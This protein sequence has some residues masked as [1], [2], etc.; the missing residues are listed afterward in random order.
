MAGT[1][2]RFASWAFSIVFLLSALALF[3]KNVVTALWLL[4]AGVVLLPPTANQ[5]AKLT[6]WT[7]PR[8]ARITAGIIGCVAL[9][10]LP[11]QYAP[12][13]TSNESIVA[14][15]FK[16]ES[17]NALGDG[18]M[19]Y[20]YISRDGKYG[21]KFFAPAI[22]PDFDA[23]YVLENTDET[24]DSTSVTYAF[25]EKTT[26]GDAVTTEAYEALQF[27]F[28]REGKLYA[29]FVRRSDA[30]GDKEGLR[31]TMKDFISELPI[32]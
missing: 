5:I 29:G 11:A 28:E 14:P 15:K 4:A 10:T 1:S 18:Y 13:Q 16:L 9:T 26:V 3:N 21:I 25:H 30:I 6:N 27:M 20:N 7:P 2:S 8:W 19:A 17:E 23:G 12:Q 31:S 24:I 22:T 32:Q